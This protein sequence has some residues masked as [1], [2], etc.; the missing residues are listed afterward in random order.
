[1]T[2]AGDTP[3]QLRFAEREGY[4]FVEVT[5]NED[6]AA[7]TLAYWQAIAAECER[8]GT[9]RLLVVD[10]LFGTPPDA[11]EL[12]GIVHVLKSSVLLGMRIAMYEPEPSQLPRLQVA[13]LEAFDVGATFRNFTSEREAEVWLRYGE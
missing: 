2:G 3:F 4:L 10:R 5:G 6:S 13:E 1:M 7:I 12:V 11:Q 9:Q 8:R